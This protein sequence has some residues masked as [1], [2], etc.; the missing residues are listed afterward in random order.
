M[1]WSAPLV[2]T[3]SG[4]GKG[5]YRESQGLT[6]TLP[7]SALQHLLAMY[8]WS[9]NLQLHLKHNETGSGAET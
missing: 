2:E 4:T 3:D 1:S 5:R 7:T 6:K 9:V 8:A